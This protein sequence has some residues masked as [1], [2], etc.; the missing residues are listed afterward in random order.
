MTLAGGPSW[1]KAVVASG[2]SLHFGGDGDKAR[3]GLP[4]GESHADRK[5]LVALSRKRRTRG[6]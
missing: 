3:L 5:R 6:L 1:A 2:R 4:S